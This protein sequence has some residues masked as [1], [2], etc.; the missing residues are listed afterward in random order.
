MYVKEYNVFTDKVLAVF[1]ASLVVPRPLKAHPTT[2][3][4][5][6]SLPLMELRSG[7]RKGDNQLHL[8]FQLAPSVRSQGDGLRSRSQRLRRWAGAA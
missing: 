8:R 1:L 3:P 2:P 6:A 7:V 5:Q 4:V